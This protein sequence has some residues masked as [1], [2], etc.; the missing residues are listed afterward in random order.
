MMTALLEVLLIKC[1]G[2]SWL[3]I[4]KLIVTEYVKLEQQVVLKY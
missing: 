3:K 1:L 2:K 4:K